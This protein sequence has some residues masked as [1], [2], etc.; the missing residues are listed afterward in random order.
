LRCIAIFRL[1]LLP[2]DLTGSNAALNEPF[3]IT[4]TDI[5][6]RYRAYEACCDNI[7]VT[8]VRK[9]WMGRSNRRFFATNGHQRPL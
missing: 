1:Q 5:G 3:G 7:T 2:I 9:R 8:D 6:D 4:S